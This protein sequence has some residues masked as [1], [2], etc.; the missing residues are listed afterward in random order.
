[1]SYETTQKTAMTQ[2][3]TE[4]LARWTVDLEE[5]GEQARRA[6]ERAYL[7][8]LASSLAGSQTPPAMMAR[9]VVERSGGHPQATLF[10][11]GLKTSA[12]QAAFANAVATH[13]LELDDLHGPSTLHPAAPIIPAALAVAEREGAGGAALLTAIAAGYEVA[14][15]IG[16][17]VN[18]AHYRFFHPT[19]TV[20]TFGAAAAS[21]K[22][23]G[24]TEEE[25]RWALG[26][27]GTQAAGLW[28]FNADGTMSKHLHPGHAALCGIFAADLAREGFS[29]TRQ[30]LEGRRGFF[31]AMAGDYDAARVTDGLGSGAPLKIESMSYKRFPCCG[32]THSG[33]D[34]ALDWS[35]EVAKEGLESLDVY[36]Y[37]VAMDIVPN[38]E[39]KTPYQAKF[40]Y[41][42]V[43]A[44]ALVHG[45][46]DVHSFAPESLEDEAVR[47]LLPRITMHHEPAFD[48][49]YPGAYAVRLVLRTRS[50]RELVALREHPKGSAHNPMSDEEMAAKA[51]GMLGDVLGERLIAHVR[52]V[53]KQP[54]LDLRELVEAPVEV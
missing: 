49:L 21:A 10:P 47:A 3:L 52:S 4:G 18:P 30:V 46:L 36:S 1:M 33:I 28:E 38:P 25:T 32:H 7:D 12:P 37:G 14:I 27:A 24:L 34:L 5:L 2:S 42:F 26:S 22:L 35:A 41:P 17:A 31:A 29:G 16:E 19:G 43:L 53:W 9:R 44:W 8:G 20:A 54:R 13:V 45:S 51:R 15:R 50:G 40:S 11:D 39:P 48:A 6:T 23:M